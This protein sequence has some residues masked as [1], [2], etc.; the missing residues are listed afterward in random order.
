LRALTNALLQNGSRMLDARNPIE[1][2]N[3]VA[4]DPALAG[5]G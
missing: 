2:R 4:P 3:E 1:H 5:E